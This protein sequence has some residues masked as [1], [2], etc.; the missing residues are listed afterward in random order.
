MDDSWPALER[1]HRHTQHWL[2]TLPER[3]VAP[4]A[5]IAEIAGKLGSVCPRIRPALPRSSTCW[6]RRASPAS[7]PC[8]PG[9]SSASS[10]AAPS[11]RPGRRLADER[12]GPELRAAPS[13]ARPQ[14][15]RGH[16]ERLAAGPARA[17]RMQRRRVRHRRHPGELHGAR[18]WPGR[19]PAGGRLGRRPA[20]A[21][22]WAAS[23]RLGRRRA[24]R[25]GR[26]G[27]A[28][29]GARVA[30]TGARR[31]A[32]AVAAD[33]LAAALDSQPATPTVVTLQA[34]TSTPVPSTR[35]PTPL[36]PRTPTARGS[37][38]TARSASGRGSRRRTGTW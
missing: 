1:A 21:C 35:S 30:R 18:G 28:L 9:G 5:S 38:S 27:S 22:G 8:R 2:S 6:P 36:P 16:C 3:P 12:L 7:P 31:R 13:H 33:A 19:R 23:A 15:R 29:P 26:P 32:R 20:R 34:E 24:A 10:S 14:R 25:G 17:A 11:G 37:T 4:Q